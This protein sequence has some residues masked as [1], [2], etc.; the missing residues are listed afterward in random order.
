MNKAY[1]QIIQSQRVDR[2]QRVR[3]NPVNWLSLIGLFPLKEGENCFGGTPD[4]QIVLPTETSGMLLLRKS[5]ISLIPMVGTDLRVNDVLPTNSSLLQTDLNGPADRIETGS[6]VMSVIQRGERLYLRVWDKESA[7]LKSFNGFHY[8]PIRPEYCLQAQFERFDP[9]RILT[10]LDVIGTENRTTFA[11]MAHFT[12]D[13]CDCTL[14][15][16]DNEGELLFSFTD[17]TR[18]DSTYPGGRKLSTA[19]PIGNVLTLDFNQTTNW[20]CAYTP[21]ATCPLPPP[22]NRLSVRIEAGEKR[23]HD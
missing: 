12:L 14:I 23:Y 15:A 5:Q 3:A 1:F 9:P 2:D 17:E 16:E 4:A 7:V 20:P 6:L 11:G 13:G 18:H 19:K 21:F 22:E 10:T 8:F